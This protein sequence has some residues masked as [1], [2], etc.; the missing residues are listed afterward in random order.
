MN[1][2]NGDTS[3]RDGRGIRQHQRGCRTNPIVSVSRLSDTYRNSWHSAPQPRQLNDHRPLAG[4]RRLL[5]WL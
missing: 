2:V 4:R 1:K 3:I 5:P